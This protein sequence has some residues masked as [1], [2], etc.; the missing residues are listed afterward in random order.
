VSRRR[1]KVV[2]AEPVREIA[3]FANDPRQLARLRGCGNHLC[4]CSTSID[5]ETL[6]FGSGELDDHGFWERPCL[7]CANDYLTRHPGAPVWPND[8]EEGF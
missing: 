4:S 3:R 1:I 8:R 7:P 6:T 5:D 2:L